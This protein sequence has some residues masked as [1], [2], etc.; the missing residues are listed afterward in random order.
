MYSKEDLQRKYEIAVNLGLSGAELLKDPR[1]QKACNGIGAEWMWD[2]LRDMLGAFNPTLTLAADIHDMRY[3]IGGNDADREFA[4]DEF[5]ENA[6]ICADAEYRWFNPLR[7]HVRKQARKFYF[8]LR[9]A[10]GK[11]WED[12]QEKGGKHE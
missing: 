12:A 10:G 8:I 2:N 7:Y 5:L 4:D 9:I 6:I 11:A 3:E 1:A